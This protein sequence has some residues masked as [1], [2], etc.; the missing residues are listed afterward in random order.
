M[1]LNQSRERKHYQVNREQ[2]TKF[3]FGL[4]PLR[5]GSFPIMSREVLS[6]SDISY[7]PSSPIRE[8]S[9]GHPQYSP[10]TSYPQHHNHNLNRGSG[11][12][13]GRGNG[14][15]H[16]G[17]GRG[18]GGY[19]GREVGGVGGSAH[20]AED[21]RGNKRRRKF[22]ESTDHDRVHWDAQGQK[23]QGDIEVSYDEISTPT[24]GHVTPRPPVSKASRDDSAANGSVKGGGASTKTEAVILTSGDAW[25]D[26]DL[27]SAWDAAIEEYHVS[28]PLFFMRRTAERTLRLVTPSD[29]QR[30]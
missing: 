30:A 27:I 4:T 25:D 20:Y 18:R 19:G 9:I 28:V 5:S 1:R 24:G 13:R 11:Q 26:T 16:G 17:R 6:Y 21:G 14:N 29:T 2:P 15:A 23:H 12:R 7:N 3:T 10:Q 8:G 22:E